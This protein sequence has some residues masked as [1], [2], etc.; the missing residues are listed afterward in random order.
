L[1]ALLF[2]DLGS[3]VGSQVDVDEREQ[4]SKAAQHAA[5][6]YRLGVP[7]KLVAGNEIA[8][9]AYSEI[10]ET[11]AQTVLPFVRHLSALHW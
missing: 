8:D 3:D 5:V 4:G 2:S 6:P 9:Y 1:D 7:T 10:V 11:S